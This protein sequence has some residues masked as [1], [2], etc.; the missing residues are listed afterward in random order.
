MN[1]KAE[2]HSNGATGN[3]FLSGGFTNIGVVP[4]YLQTWPQVS[5]IDPAG[6]PL[7]I[8]YIYWDTSNATP[9]AGAT[10]RA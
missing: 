10:E 8:T 3:I 7:D 4:C 1:L 9:G 6:K 5:L 2:A